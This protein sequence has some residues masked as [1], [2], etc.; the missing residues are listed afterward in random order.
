MRRIGLL[1][2]L[3]IANR[4]GGQQPAELQIPGRPTC[5]ACRIELRVIDTLVAPDA[6]EP[7]GYRS[8]VA[9]GADGRFAVVSGNGKR[10]LV[11]DASGRFL[12]QVGVTG[13]GPGEFEKVNLVRFA[14]A[15]TV[16]AFETR[17]V[18]VL[19]PTFRPA[20]T[21][22]LPGT[23]QAA[24]LLP[25]G[26]LLIAAR[27][28]APNAVGFPL[29][30]VDGAGKV[31][32]SFGWRGDPVVDPKCRVCGR[33][34]A[35]GGAPAVVLIHP[36]RYT[37]EEWSTEGS[38]LRSIT[39][40]STWLQPWTTPSDHLGGNEPQR[41]AISQ[42]TVDSL[43]RSWIYGLR[44]P[45]NW[46]RG[47]VPI[48]TSKWMYR[49]GRIEFRTLDAMDEWTAAFDGMQESVIEVVDTKRNA[50]LA[51]TAFSGTML[52]LGDGFAARKRELPSGE[53]GVEVGRLILRER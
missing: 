31:L 5:A 51:S 42:V 38:I 8:D 15:D 50:V 3:A 9:R 22:S 45:A 25:N 37:W 53:I 49:D 32:K 23:P 46:K 41:P 10:I 11:F 52:L 34:M 28:S 20:R 35:R 4:A 6:A 43:G 48:D 18:H 12:Q 29:H 36:N 1:L 2:A 19:T 26:S 13:R 14:S 17:R 16:L 24:R 30:V 40:A 27:V 21:V 39:V 7:I 33:T 44:P 47:M